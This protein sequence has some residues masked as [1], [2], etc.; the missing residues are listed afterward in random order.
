MAAFFKKNDS[1]RY[2]SNEQRRRQSIT[3]R[4]QCF[5]GS[6]PKADRAVD[7]IGD[8]EAVDS[9]QINVP[10]AMSHGIRVLALVDQ[11]RLRED[12]VAFQPPI[13]PACLK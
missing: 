12:L 8:E 3:E 11:V 5:G 9:V 4:A 13:S 1:L 10:A 6:T 2:W 7:E